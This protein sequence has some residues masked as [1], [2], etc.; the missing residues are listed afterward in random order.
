MTIFSNNGKYY[1]WIVRKVCTFNLLSSESF[2]YMTETL[3]QH[4]KT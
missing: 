3:P 2:S 4:T 1:K